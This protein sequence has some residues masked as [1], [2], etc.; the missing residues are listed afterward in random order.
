MMRYLFP[1][2]FLSS[3]SRRRPLPLA[4]L[5]LSLVLALVAM[6]PVAVS[7][8]AEPRPTLTT[9]PAAAVTLP[10][11]RQLPAGPRRKDAF[12]Q[13]LVPIVEAENSRLAARREWL[14]ALAERDT[15]WTRA[16]RERVTAL[17]KEY[18][19]DCEPGKINALLLK[20]VAPVP[21]EMVAVQAVEESG[22]GTSRLARQNNNLFGMRTSG[23]RYQSFDSLQDA[24]RA[25]LKNLNTH[26]AYADLR[27]RRAQLSAQGEVPPEAL[28]AMLNDYA[29]RSDYQHVLLS[30]LRTN[31]ERIRRYA[32]DTPA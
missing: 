16:E 6:P 3:P 1:W 10:D 19:L 28:I 12:L 5:V 9:E 7:Q 27:A 11:L 21:L 24:V 26:R 23:G 30:L 32:G 29:T 22:W 18:A 13:V 17:C 20:R 15:P 2:C 25:Y 4:L 31:A 8:P 14:M